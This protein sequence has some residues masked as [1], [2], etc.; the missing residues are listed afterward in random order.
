MCVGRGRAWGKKSLAGNLLD[1]WHAEKE[2]DSFR[3]A[4]IWVAIP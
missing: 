3:S 4:V 2:M 1:W